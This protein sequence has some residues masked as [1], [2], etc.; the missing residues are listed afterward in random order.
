MRAYEKAVALDKTDLWSL[1]GI[2]N[3]L[4][5]MERKDDARRKYEEVIDRAGSAQNDAEYPY[6]LIGWCQYGLGHYD[7]AIRAYLTYNS[8]GKGELPE[9]FD[10]ALL[11]M[12]AGRSAIGLAAYRKALE[13]C[14]NNR[15]YARG[16]VTRF[17]VRPNELREQIQN[18]NWRLGS[19]VQVGAQTADR[20]GLP[21]R[22]PDEER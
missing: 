19:V 4:R 12:C 7:E 17:Q 9:E 21:C 8:S 20:A 6:W 3:V 13:K 11:Q 1:K 2:G 18:G 15:S 16:Y 10:F 14:N 5:Q 22:C